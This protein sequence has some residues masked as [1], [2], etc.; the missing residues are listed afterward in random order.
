MYQY[1]KLR[2]RI[3]EICHTQERFA[4]L[5]NI[6]KSTMSAKLNGHVEFT[7]EEITQACMI[8]NID[9]VNIHEYFF[10]KKFQKNEAEV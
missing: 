1:N 4:D 10:D 7:Q 2:G 8:L 9:H 3:R 6:S 5:M